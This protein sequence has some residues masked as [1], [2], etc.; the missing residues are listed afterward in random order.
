MDPGEV[1]L[2]FIMMGAFCSG[3]QDG[4]KAWNRGG[5]ATSA[6]GKDYIKWV[7][8][9]VSYEASARHMT[10]MWIRLTRNIMWSGSRCLHIPQPEPEGI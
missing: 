4:Q 2:L 6:A 10:G 1:M 8:F 9:T 3:R 7:D 5:H